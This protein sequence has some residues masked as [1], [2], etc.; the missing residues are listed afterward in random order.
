MKGIK[1]VRFCGGFR[2]FFEKMR[3]KVSL[4]ILWDTCVGKFVIKVPPNRFEEYQDNIIY[5]KAELH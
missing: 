1:I 2:I 5:Q 4:E 3:S